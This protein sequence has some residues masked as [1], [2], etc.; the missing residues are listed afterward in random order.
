MGEGKGRVG[1]RT[2]GQTVEPSLHHKP[3]TYIVIV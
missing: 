1:S 2:L 3:N